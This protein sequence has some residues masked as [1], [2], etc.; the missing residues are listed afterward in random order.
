MASTRTDYRRTARLDRTA[1]PPKRLQT[2]CGFAVP[3][4]D[5]QGERNTLHK[6]AETQ[7]AAGVR[8]YWTQATIQSIDGLPTPLAQRDDA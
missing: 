6:W 2:S 5:H 4:L 7:G 1:A 3:F 8:D